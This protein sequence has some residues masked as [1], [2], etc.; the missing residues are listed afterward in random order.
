MK[1]YIVR[2][3]TGQYISNCRIGSNYMT[4]DRTDSPEAA[5]RLYDFDSKLVIKRLKSEGLKAEREEVEPR[6]EGR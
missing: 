3:S 1:Q 6:P 5:T 4:Y 2:L